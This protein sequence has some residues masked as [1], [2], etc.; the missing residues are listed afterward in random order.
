MGNN[1]EDYSGE[2][3]FKS[4]QGRVL[5]AHLWLHLILTVDTDLSSFIV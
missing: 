5:H 1:G 4:P 3:E 2:I